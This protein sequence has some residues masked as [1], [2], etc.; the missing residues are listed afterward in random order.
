MENL[1][2]NRPKRP[3][4]YVALATLWGN[5]GERELDLYQQALAIDSDYVPALLLL[6]RCY[7]EAGR[8][9]SAEA[10][11]NR[12]IHLHP[13]FITA[14]YELGR[15]LSGLG[16]SAEAEPYLRKA[17]EGACEDNIGRCA[18]DILEGKKQPNRILE[19][20]IFPKLNIPVGLRLVVSAFA[21]FFVAG[22]ISV[23]TEM[24]NRT[25]FGA[26]VG[27]VVYGVLS[28]LSSKE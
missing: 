26:F 5:E 21:I 14:H 6:A 4:L 9:E 8:Y 20:H 13:E 25:I 3:D 1:I 10:L 16:R 17:M 28:A 18:A 23:I 22:P 24:S 27:A 15:L 7:V 2:S 19:K 11:L 12:S